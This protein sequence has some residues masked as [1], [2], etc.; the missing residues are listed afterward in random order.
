MTV[1]ST[2]PTLSK[3]NSPSVSQET[4]NKSLEIAE[5][6]KY[7]DEIVEVLTKAFEDGAT[8]TEACHIAQIDRKTYYNWRDSIPDFFH[9]MDQAQEY[10]DAVAKM[11]T[12]KAMK[13]GDVDT[14]KWWLER[15]L[16]SEFSL[17]QEHTGKDGESLFGWQ[18]DNNTLQPNA[19]PESPAQFQE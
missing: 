2:E 5:Q 3:A 8:I 16:K 19:S 14:A 11:V 13:K 17:R 7:S 4:K 18:N 1:Q 15:R 12:V 10:P 6:S 9:K